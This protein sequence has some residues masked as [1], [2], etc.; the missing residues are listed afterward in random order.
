MVNG[1]GIAA[2]GSQR[3]RLP[4]P[5]TRR[6]GVGRPGLLLFADSGR[7]R[8]PPKAKPPLAFTDPGVDHHRKGRD[9]HSEHGPQEHSSEGRVG[10]EAS[11]P[12][13]QPPDRR[14]D[15]AQPL[16]EIGEPL[17]RLGRRRRRLKRELDRRIGPQRRMRR[18][19]SVGGTGRVLRLFS[20]LTPPPPRAGECRELD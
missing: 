19:Q 5:G 20:D 11:D 3:V 17:R 9:S 14:E 7:S 10:H 8:G 15:L 6:R 12:P 13:E 16:D 1:L 2:L 18:R 4:E